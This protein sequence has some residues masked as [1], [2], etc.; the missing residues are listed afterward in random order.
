MLWVFQSIKCLEIS[1][2]GKIYKKEAPELEMCRVGFSR[3]FFVYSLAKEFKTGL[4]GPLPPTHL[5]EYA[6]CGDQSDHE[7][8]STGWK[9]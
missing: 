4:L 5:R 8:Q 6:V 1:C 9:R 2:F 3:V 7:V